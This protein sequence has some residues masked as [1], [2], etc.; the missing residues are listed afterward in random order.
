MNAK[1]NSTQKFVGLLYINEVFDD[2]V[3][4]LKSLRS[5]ITIKAQLF[6]EIRII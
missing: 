3:S 1:I 4:V 5:L 2:I 6:C